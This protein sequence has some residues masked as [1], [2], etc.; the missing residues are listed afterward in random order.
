MTLLPKTV[1]LTPLEAAAEERGQKKKRLIWS[2]D[3]RRSSVQ[4]RWLTAPSVNKPRTL[5]CD[6]LAPSRPSDSS[7]GGQGIFYTYC[8]KSSYAESTNFINSLIINV[9]LMMK[10][11]CT[12]VFFILSPACCCQQAD[13]YGWYI[14]TQVTT[15]AVQLWC[16]KRYCISAVAH[17]ECT[18]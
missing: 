12:V 7:W 5:F 11:D 4:S 13:C 2:V 14:N 10:I 3:R 15:D 16:I 17:L 9:F 18:N 8:I 1:F 6:Q